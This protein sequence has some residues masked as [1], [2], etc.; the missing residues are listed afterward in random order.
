MLKH[1]LHCLFVI[2]SK[3]NEDLLIYLSAAAPPMVLINWSEVTQA[4]IISCITGTIPVLIKHWYRESSK[5][6]KDDE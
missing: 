3:V 1:A 4:I 5:N 6:Q 2:L